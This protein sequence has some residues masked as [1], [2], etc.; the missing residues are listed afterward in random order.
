MVKTKVLSP[1]AGRRRGRKMAALV[2]QVEKMV[3]APAVPGQGISRGAR[4]RRAQGRM[5]P[6]EYVEAPVALG[7]RRVN[8]VARVSG[9]G[10]VVVVQH[11]EYVADVIGSIPY[12][13]L[14]YAV[15]PGVS[16]TFPWLSVLA[17]NFEKYRFRRLDFCFESSVATTAAGV[18]LSAIDLDANDPAPPSKQVIMA[19]Q[20]ASRSNVWME[21]CTRLPEMQP[22]LYVRTATAPAS[23]DIKTYDAGNLWLAVQG[24]IDSTSAIG[25]LYVDYVVELHVPQLAAVANNPA[26]S[27]T[28]TLISFL[29]ATFAGAAPYVL[30]VNNFQLG[31][32]LPLNARILITTTVVGTTPGTGATVSVATA[33]S[34]PG[35][36]G[37]LIGSVTPSA[38][39]AVSQFVFQV[40]GVTTGGGGLPTGYFYVNI[41][42]GTI[43]GVIEFFLDAVA[44]QTGLAFP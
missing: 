37:V 44:W 41:A 35:N 6:L 28:N 23:T 17:R 15:N 4:R 27:V 7:V 9:T 31:F 36:A 40:T 42:P 34:Y 30:G 11:R 14:G 26:L 25:E 5:G 12:S 33:A 29:G 43:G 32:L 38:S 2:K 24:T 22:E 21:S 3:V 8:P 16:T 39:T 10:N 20:G 13:V 1:A 18:V 19:Y